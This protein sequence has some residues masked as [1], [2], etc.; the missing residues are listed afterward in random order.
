MKTGRSEGL[1]GRSLQENRIL[2]SILL[3]G[4][5]NKDVWWSY[6]NLRTDEVQRYL[7]K[8]VDRT[9]WIL[10]EDLTGILELVEDKTWFKKKIN[11]TLPSFVNRVK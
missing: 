2:V 8:Y 1:L 9:D 5:G 11:G 4:F 3:E 7:Y 10:K 6:T